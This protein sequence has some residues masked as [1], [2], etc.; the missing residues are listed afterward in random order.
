MVG[1][2]CFNTEWPAIQEIYTDAILILDRLI[3]TTTPLLRNYVCASIRKSREFWLT[4]R[5]VVIVVNSFSEVILGLT[6]KVRLQDLVV[7]AN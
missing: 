3:V 6:Q 4:L 1:E 7:V 2:I 5:L